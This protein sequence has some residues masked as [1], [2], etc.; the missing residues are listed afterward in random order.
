M[1]AETIGGEKPHPMP[2]YR[3]GVCG[4]PHI[5]LAGWV[6]VNTGKI[7]GWGSD[8]PCDAMFC[9]NCATQHSEHAMREMGTPGTPCNE[10][11]NQVHADGSE[12]PD[13]C[14]TKSAAGRETKPK[15]GECEACRG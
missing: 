15:P 5:Q 12:C 1:S 4:C 2:E 13:S 8:G 14:E 9:T 10:H 7:D 11:M 6:D 3:C